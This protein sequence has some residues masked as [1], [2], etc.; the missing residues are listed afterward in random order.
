MSI[1]IEI[2]WGSESKL[3]S[4]IP[5]FVDETVRK[6]ALVILCCYDLCEPQ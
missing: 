4:E 5:T 2:K 3:F 1:E 6:L